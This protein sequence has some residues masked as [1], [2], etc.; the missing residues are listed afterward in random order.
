MSPTSPIRLGTIFAL[1]KLTH[2]RAA[3]SL[4]FS[5]VK[6]RPPQTLWQRAWSPA[7]LRALRSALPSFPL[8]ARDERAQRRRR[9]L[10]LAWRAYRRGG[11][12]QARVDLG[13]TAV[14]L[15]VLEAEAQGLPYVLVCS[16][17]REWMERYA[18]QP[19]ADPGD[20]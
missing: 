1:F 19:P 16:S 14:F 12:W 2:Y 7:F 8:Q 11:Q 17:G 10:R 18:E 5:Q 9:R 6:S 20:Q 3:H 15:D 13:E 4:C